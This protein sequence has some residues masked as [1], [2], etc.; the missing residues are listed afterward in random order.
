MT[1]EHTL[2]YPLDFPQLKWLFETYLDGGSERNEFLKIRP[3]RHVDY[4]RSYETDFADE[5]AFY[6]YLEQLNNWIYENGSE[7]DLLT[8]LAE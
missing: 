4:E 5:R 7:P 6:D 3:L 2:K 8:F 1:S